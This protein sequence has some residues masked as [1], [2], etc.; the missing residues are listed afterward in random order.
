LP[1]GF[2]GDEA[3][4]LMRYAGLSPA[5]RS[6]GIYG[7]DAVA[8]PGNIAAM[9]VAQMI[10]YFL[11]GR[12]RGSREAVIHDKEAFNEFHIAFA[13][14]DTTF[15]QSKRTGRWWMQLPDKQFIACSYNDYLLA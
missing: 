10:W 14:V 8:D 9:Q 11:E 7:Y 2:T 13:E 3:C 4:T 5:C 1:N 15:L 12:S 6:V